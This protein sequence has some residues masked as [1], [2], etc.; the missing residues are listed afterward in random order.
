MH[1]IRAE[2]R[3]AL[4]SGECAGTAPPA[5]TASLHPPRARQHAHVHA[6]AHA[7]HAHVWAWVCADRDGMTQ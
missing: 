5:S 2:A 1:L 7:T 3:K 6:H 4:D